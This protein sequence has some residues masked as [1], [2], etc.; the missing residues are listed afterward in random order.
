MYARAHMVSGEEFISCLIEMS[1]LLMITR[2][3]ENERGRERDEIKKHDNSS[4]STFCYSSGLRIFAVRN[5]CGIRPR[6]F[7][8]ETIVGYLL[9]FRLCRANFL[10]LT[11]ADRDGNTRHWLKCPE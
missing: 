10:Q 8:R 2:E 1:F 7:E 4:L 5:T 3:G 6:T 11:R 9:G